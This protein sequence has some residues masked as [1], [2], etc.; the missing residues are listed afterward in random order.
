MTWKV[1]A[2]RRL[3]RGAA[4]G[5]SAR[6]RRCA[7]APPNSPRSSATV[8]MYL[9]SRRVISWA[10]PTAVYILPYHSYFQICI[11]CFYN[12]WRIYKFPACRLFNFYRPYFLLGVQLVV[13]SALWLQLSQKQPSE[14]R[15]FWQTIFL[16]HPVHHHHP[17]HNSIYKI[18]GVRKKNPQT[19]F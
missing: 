2:R 12:Q 9:A 6:L 4:G 13:N 15:L 17:F 16:G 19:F 11:V 1:F 3:G 10:T 8:I 14:S 7:G 5:G 18:I